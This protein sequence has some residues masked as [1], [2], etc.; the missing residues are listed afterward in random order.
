[1]LENE[2]IGQF[3]TT[4]ERPLF[5]VEGLAANPAI[6]NDALCNREGFYK[7]QN[8][9]VRIRAGMRKYIPGSDPRRFLDD[10]D[11][12]RFDLEELGIGSITEFLI[13]GTLANLQKLESL[14][15]T[16]KPEEA[17]LV[18]D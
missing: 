7:Y 12:Y 11:L 15:R 9:G 1:M 10:L 17:P 8:T 3:K 16:F 2:A 5:E 6:L 13:H 4:L 14:A 18:T